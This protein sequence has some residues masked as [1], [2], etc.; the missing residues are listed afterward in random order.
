LN[1]P[2]TP[3]HLTEGWPDD[4]NR[5]EVE[6]FARELQGK[7]PELPSD[8]IQRIGGQMHDE[9][10][11][12]RWRKRRLRMIATISTI[13]ASLLIG[14]VIWRVNDATAP[15]AQRSTDQLAVRG[16]PAVRDQYRVPIMAAPALPVPDAVTL[17]PVDEQKRMGNPLL[18]NDRP[19]VAVENHRSLFANE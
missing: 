2:P 4:P 11:L 19:L 9:M 10:A 3:D 8:A 7:L 5:A 13:A 6:A 14:I 18:R 15:L 12:Q 17:L 16:V 1:D